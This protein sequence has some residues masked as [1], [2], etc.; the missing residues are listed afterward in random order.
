MD[1]Q[2]KAIGSRQSQ[3]ISIKFKLVPG[4][5]G[6]GLFG[7]GSKGD[8]ANSFPQSSNLNFGSYA[9]S[10][11]GNGREILSIEA[12]DSSL[13]T[14]TLEL[15]CALSKFDIDT[16]VGERADKFSEKSSRDGD[17]TFLFYFGTNP[18]ADGNL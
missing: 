6:A 8:L 11:L 14:G 5:H 2:S 18:A 10:N 16:V 4:K 13:E 7:S 17:G 1:S 3:L 15:K 9:V 12:I